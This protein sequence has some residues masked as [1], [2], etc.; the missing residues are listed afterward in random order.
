MPHRAFGPAI[1]VPGLSIADK[2][3]A[4]A[5]TELNEFGIDAPLMWDIE[6]KMGQ[7]TWAH[8]EQTWQGMSRS[9]EASSSPNGGM[10]EL[11]MWGADWYLGIPED[12]T[13]AFVARQRSKKR[14]LLGVVFDEW[15]EVEMG[16][17]A[18]VPTRG[19]ADELNWHLVRTWTIAGRQG[20]IPRRYETG[21]DVQTGEVVWRQNLVMHIDG[22]WG[23]PAM[24]GKPERA[25]LRMGVDRPI[26]TPP[27]VISGAITSDVHELYPYQDAVNLS[28][29]GAGASVC[30]TNRS[31]GC[32]WRIH[33]HGGR[34]ANCQCGPGGP[35]EH[36]LHEWEYAQHQC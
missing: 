31:H 33:H 5:A 9:K 34:S 22:K 28:L 7:H 27:L 19:E 23:M 30:W 20:T 11:I 13:E 12:A 2:A 6:S 4:F 18:W 15:G 16:E 36:D 1:D 25:V 24:N 3:S 8:A 26:V 14:P 21:I 10:I 32:G 17:L 29:P 35:L